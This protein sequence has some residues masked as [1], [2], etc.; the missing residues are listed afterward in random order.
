MDNERG[1]SPFSFNSVCNA[2]K[3]TLS[4]FSVK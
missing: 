3:R 2:L 4:A 1:E